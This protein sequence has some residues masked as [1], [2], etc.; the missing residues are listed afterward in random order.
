MTN[1]HIQPD[2]PQRNACIGRGNG[3]LRREGLGRYII[4]TIETAEVFA[5][6]WLRTCNNDRPTMGIGG[7]TITRRAPPPQTCAS[8]AADRS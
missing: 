3:T 2:Q 1:Q 6:Q 5:T 8:G 4:E 7:I